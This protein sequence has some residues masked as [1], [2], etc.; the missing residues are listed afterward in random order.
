MRTCQRAGVRV[1]MFTE[2]NAES[3]AATGKKIGL[4]GKVVT[5]KS[6]S[7]SVKYGTELPLDADIYARVT[8]EQK[9][10]VI[11]E[12]RKNGDIVAMTGT[13]A[14]DAEA[15]D[16]ADIGITI[17]ESTTGSAYEA[18]DV[19]M[20]DDN[21]SA[22][23]GMIASA[24]QVHR[25]IK[26]ASAVMISGYLALVLLNMLNLFGDAQLMLNPAIIA[27]LTM[28]VLPA[29]ALADLNNHS[30]MKNYMPPSDFITN[31]RINYRYIALAAIVGA[32]CGAVSIA[33]Y[34]FMYNG[35]NVDFARSCALISFG[36]CTSLFTFINMTSGNPFTGIAA[37][38]KPALIGVLAPAVTA[39]LLVFIPG[40]NSI[41]GMTG[42][43][44]LATF[45]SIVTGII[46]PLAYVV[47][48]S[49]VKFE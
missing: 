37:A 44:I 48:R 5:G 41:F 8:P 27:V 10:Y 13:R 43:D 11:E 6:I 45:I 34:M 23:A 20:N 38:G 30:D 47:V 40:V 19:I 17:S 3:A 39:L 2:D 1:V 46:P 32:L 4:A 29:A 36:F 42:I 16:R 33:S 28:F 49:I 21:F 31:R 18:A 35:V 24:R 9:L 22:I 26:R 15:M 25:N 7:E 12:M 14:E